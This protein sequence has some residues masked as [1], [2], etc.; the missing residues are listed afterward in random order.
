MTMKIVKSVISRTENPPYK[1][2]EEV[3][4]FFSS[5]G[6]DW[7]IE[8]SPVGGQK[9]HWSFYCKTKQ[10]MYFC[11]IY[12]GGQWYQNLDELSLPFTSLAEGYY[13]LLEAEFLEVDKNYHALLRQMK[14][15]SFWKDREGKNE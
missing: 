1:E 10:W 15:V 6:G 12:K 4:T 14:S 13:F 7:D 9:R 5:L 11:L 3:K 8:V 2:V